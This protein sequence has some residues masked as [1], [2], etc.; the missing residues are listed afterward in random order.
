MTTPTPHVIVAA[1]TI[2]LSGCP[3]FQEQHRA[4]REHAEGR[5]Q[6]TPF[7][8]NVGAN[9]PPPEGW[10]RSMLWPGYRWQFRGHR[11]RVREWQQQYAWELRA[12]NTRPQERAA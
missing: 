8:L 2:D 12:L 3:T 1:E 9:F 4:L 11:E 10:M 7:A 5:P 6:G